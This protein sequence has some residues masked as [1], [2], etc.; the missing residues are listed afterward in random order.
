MNANFEKN[1]NFIPHIFRHSIYQQ[2]GLQTKLEAWAH[3]TH[4]DDEWYAQLRNVPQY[5]RSWSL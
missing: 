4:D 1:A 5:L 2:N 3:A